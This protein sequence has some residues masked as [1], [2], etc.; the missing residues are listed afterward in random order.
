MD[1]SHC[2]V[3]RLKARDGVQRKWGRKDEVEDGESSRVTRLT[4]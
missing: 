2:A 1:H 4:G 3:G